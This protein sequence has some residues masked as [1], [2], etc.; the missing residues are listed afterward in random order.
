[1]PA[2][3]VFRLEDGQI[4]AGHRL[5]ADDVEHALALTR[6]MLDHGAAFEVWDRH[7]LAAKWPRAP[8]SPEWP[9]RAET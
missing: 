7:G 5:E 2:Y 4:T 6:E 3:R 9:L 8:L 1:V